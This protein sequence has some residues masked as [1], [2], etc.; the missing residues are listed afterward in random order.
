MCCAMCCIKTMILQCEVPYADLKDNF[1]VGMYAWYSTLKEPVLEARLKKEMFD[2]SM[3]K[4]IAHRIPDVWVNGKI[5]NRYLKNVI[6]NLEYPI[7]IDPSKNV[8]DELEKKPV[9]NPEFD[10]LNYF[11]DSQLKEEGLIN[12]YSGYNDNKIKIKNKSFLDKLKSILSKNRK[13]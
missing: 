9:L 11:P 13:R 4:G 12:S 10:F 5:Y 2:R 7:L 3:I 6:N 1:G 8:I